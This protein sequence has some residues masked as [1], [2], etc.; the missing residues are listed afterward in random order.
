MDIIRRL[1]ARLATRKRGLAFGGSITPT[2]PSGTQ[3]GDWLILI[4]HRT[5]T[6]FLRQHPDTTW[7]PMPI[8]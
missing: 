2:L 8:E 7:R 3:D 5:D 1:L 4:D 6:A